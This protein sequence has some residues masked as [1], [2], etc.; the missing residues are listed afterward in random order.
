VAN[1]PQVKAAVAQCKTAINSAPQLSAASKTKLD[2]LCD[3]AASGKLTDLKQVTYQV[4]QQV[5]K[6]SVPQA[7]QQAAL[8]SCPK[9]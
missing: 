1:N 4:C 2:A 3:K 9:P 7:Q 8:A 5:I 6:D